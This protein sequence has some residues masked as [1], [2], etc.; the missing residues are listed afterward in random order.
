LRL[1]TNG[2][3]SA[4]MPTNL[5]CGAL[6]LLMTAITNGPL[7]QPGDALASYRTQCEAFVD[8]FRIVGTESQSP[9]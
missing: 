2:T 3:F 4:A 1:A 9:S 8:A 7:A 5:R 6:A